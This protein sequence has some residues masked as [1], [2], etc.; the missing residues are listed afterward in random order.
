MTEKRAETA[1]S[2]PPEAPEQRKQAN[3][4]QL[5]GTNRVSL[6]YLPLASG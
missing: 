1:T 2:P 5:L 4:C 6:T 3:S